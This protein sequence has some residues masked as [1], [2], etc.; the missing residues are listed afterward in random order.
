MPDGLGVFYRS[1]H[2]KDAAA[3]KVADYREFVAP[4]VD[5]LAPE[6]LVFL[7]SQW[8][9]LQEEAA[10]DQ[11]VVA[12]DLQQLQNV[13]RAR[14]QHLAAEGRVSKEDAAD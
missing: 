8:R 11:P 7:K 12:K 6:T 2:S 4:E 9:R 14:L 3:M 13:F 1:G 5:S 10:W